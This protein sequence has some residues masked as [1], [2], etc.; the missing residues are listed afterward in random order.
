MIEKEIQQI[1]GNIKKKLEDVDKMLYFT[2]CYSESRSI[3]YCF[4]FHFKIGKLF[5]NSPVI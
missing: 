3:L 2:K 1:Q 4:K 5:F